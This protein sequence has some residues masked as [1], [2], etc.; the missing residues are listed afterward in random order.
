MVAA[1]AKKTFTWVDGPFSPGEEVVNWY[2]NRIM[3][4]FAVNAVLVMDFRF[5]GREY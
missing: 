1:E 5:D 3:E 2:A 4:T